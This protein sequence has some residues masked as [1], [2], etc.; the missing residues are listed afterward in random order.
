MEL[1]VLNRLYALQATREI[2]TIK[3]EYPEVQEIERQFA[4]LLQGD[5]DYEFWD[6]L[7]KAIKGFLFRLMVLPLP[8]SAALF[9]CFGE[10]SSV[11]KQGHWLHP[12]VAADFNRVY[13]LS[14]QLRSSNKNPILEVIQR[15]GLG[16]ILV[17][18]WKSFATATDEYLSH[19]GYRLRVV[20]Q[21][22]LDRTEALWGDE[23]LIVVGPPRIYEESLFTV[24]RSSL[25]TWLTFAWKPLRF[26]V[27]NQLIDHSHK[28]APKVAPPV[29]P[30]AGSESGV[31][32]PV[33]II[34][35]DSAVVRTASHS[36]LVPAR[37]VWLADDGRVFVHAGDRAK[38]WILDVE[39]V[40]PRARPT[41][42]DELMPGDFLIVRTRGGGDLIVPV[43]DTIIGPNHWLLRNNLILWKAALRDLAARN[44]LDQLTQMLRNQGA[45]SLAS[46]GNIRYW[47]SYFS[48]GPSRKGDLI[49]CLSLLG[50]EDKA[51]TLWTECRRLA[52]AHRL[53][54]R[55]IRRMLL[56]Q[57]STLTEKDI[58]TGRIDLALPNEPTAAAAAVEIVRID[59]TV[60]Q[61]PSA[62]VGVYQEAF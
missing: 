56:D 61:I 21:S 3:V 17:V 10:V 44:G 42:S 58:A 49:A 37:T 45:S 33:D 55:Q 29:T 27:R 40:P 14:R 41:P 60:V 36:D 62:S 19:I 31:D 43:A 26:D 13:D 2:T 50:M 6:P 9:D 39:S 51:D 16:G 47:M 28:S 23:N 59:R 25:L 1:R 22:A 12:A 8:P 18:P 46:P 35:N 52:R 4:H 48:I 57:A 24:R 38:S 5:I 11:L 53:A 20:S 7:I 32:M 34:L 15:Q 30:N 54:G